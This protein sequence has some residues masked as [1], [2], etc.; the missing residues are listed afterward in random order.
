MDSLFALYLILSFLI[1]SIFVTVSTILGERFGSRIGGL[2]GGLPSTVAV[3][4]FFIGLSQS[5]Q[6]ASQATTVFPLIYAFTGLFL[7]IFALAARRGFWIA[8]IVSLFL[9][10]ALSLTAIMF[11]WNSFLLSF[12]LYV[13]IAVTA[14]SIFQFKLKLSFTEKIRFKYTSKQIAGRAIFSGFMIAFAVLSSKLGGPIFGG[15]F[16]AFPAVF[17]SILVISYKSQGIAL[18]RAMT[19]PLFITGMISVVTYA[20]AVRYFYL[21]VGLVWG[22]MGAYLLSIAG[23]F[24]SYL[25]QNRL[26]QK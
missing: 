10:I 3:A 20:T 16:S 21:S 5:L 25:L 17:I 19:K 4:F 26:Q 1:G 13:V 7:L 24:F 18:S 15:A 8:L 2:I 6:A 14:F 12:L 9:W 22:T 11:R 23:A